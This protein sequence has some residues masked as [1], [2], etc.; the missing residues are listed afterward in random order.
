MTREERLRR[1][2]EA[3]DGQPV[4][5]GARVA[6]V[7]AAVASGRGMYVDLSKIPD[8]DRQAVA[9][10]IR[11]LIDTWSNTARKP[12]APHAHAGVPAAT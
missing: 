6:Q 10:Q 3:E 2:A 1:A 7:N 12:D 9:A 4:S 8:G 11:T 5:A